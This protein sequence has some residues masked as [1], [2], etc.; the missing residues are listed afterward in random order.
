MIITTKTLCRII[1]STYLDQFNHTH[2]CWLV[3]DTVRVGPEGK[4]Y[5]YE[6]Y[7]NII[8]DPLYKSLEDD[9]QFRH[10][11]P[12][13]YGCASTWSRTNVAGGLQRERWIEDSRKKDDT[14]PWYY[15]LYALIFGEP[16]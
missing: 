7:T 16:L 6:Y 11:M 8:K 4:S 1:E 5:D 9:R 10:H 13:D 14:G 15:G 3:V 12:T 2:K